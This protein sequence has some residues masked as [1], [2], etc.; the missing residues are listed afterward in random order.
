D[1]LR[2]DARQRHL[3]FSVRAVVRRLPDGQR[4]EPR[5]LRQA[6]AMIA[7]LAL[8]AMFGL[9]APGRVI[10]DVRVHG[11]HSTPDAV[12]L[13]IAGINVGDTATPETPGLVETRLRRS[14]RFND[15]EVLAR[16]RTL[17]GSDMALVIIVREEYVLPID[18]PGGGVARVARKIGNT[19]LFLPILDFGDYGFSYGLRASFVDVTGQGSRVSVPFTWG[20]EKR[21]AVEYTHRFGA[22]GRVMADARASWQRLENPFYEIDDSRRT[23]EAGVSWQIAR[24]LRAAAHAGVTDVSFDE[25]DERFPW[26]RASVTLDTRLDPSLP[27]NAVYASIGV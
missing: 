24:S 19:P 17:D 21:A 5:P 11:N 13:E 15:V 22:D 25:I 23:A 26:G 7:A 12:V 18:E 3:Q 16:S 1:G 9:Q 2:D 20:G 10:S 6:A 14:G 8:V 27:R 4:H